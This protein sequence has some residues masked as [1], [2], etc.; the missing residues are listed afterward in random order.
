[1]VRLRVGLGRRRCT[2]TASQTAN[3]KA[4]PPL[5]AGDSTD[6]REGLVPHAWHR[7]L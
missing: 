1:M 7:G 5:G 6:R 3:P 2:Q 4:L